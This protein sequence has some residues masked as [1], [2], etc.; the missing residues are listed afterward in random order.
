MRAVRAVIENGRV[1]PVEPLDVTGRRD[2]IVILLDRNPWD[3]ILDDPRPRPAL[4]KAAE[5][6]HQEYV[7]GRT[8][9]LDPDTMS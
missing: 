2:A 5:E 7:H 8:M 6:A 9:P 1:V 4:E 3:A